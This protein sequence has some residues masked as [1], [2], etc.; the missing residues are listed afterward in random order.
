MDDLDHKILQTQQQLAD[1]QARLARLIGRVESAYDRLVDDP[2][3]R[4]LIRAKAWLHH[5][6]TLIVSYDGSAVKCV[7]DGWPESVPDPEEHVASDVA[8]RRDSYIDT[9][10][11]RGETTGPGPT[12]T[13]SVERFRHMIGDAT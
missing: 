13:P 10:L 9:T 5:D 11:G 6:P 12:A 4:E 7:P 1:V 2:V 3:H 8:A